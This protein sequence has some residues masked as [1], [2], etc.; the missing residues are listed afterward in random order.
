VRPAAP[1]EAAGY[2]LRGKAAAGELGR[3]DGQTAEFCVTQG[4]EARSMARGATEKD[5]SGRSRH[6]LLSACNSMR[7]ERLYLCDLRRT[8]HQPVHV[9]A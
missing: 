4:M 5:L 9:P 8:N 7:S 6:P 1:Q 3:V 2:D